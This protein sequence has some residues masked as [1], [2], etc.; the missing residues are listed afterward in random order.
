MEDLGIRLED[1][2]KVVLKEFDWKG[3]DWNYMVQD[4]KKWQAVVAAV[5]NLRV[6]YNSWNFLTS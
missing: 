1:D 3:V 5:M 2:I 4:R 6:P